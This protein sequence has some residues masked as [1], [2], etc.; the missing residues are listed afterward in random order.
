MPF[1]IPREADKYA[2]AR[3]RADPVTRTERK[4][5]CTRARVAGV[6]WSVVGARGERF[7]RGISRRGGRAGARVRKRLLASVIAPL[8]SV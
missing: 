6:V 2:R 3:T 1:K 4:C 7:S 8:V 5:A